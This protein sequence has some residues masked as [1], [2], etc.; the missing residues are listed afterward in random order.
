MKEIKKQIQKIF[1]EVAE[2][3]I[4]NGHVNMYKS[5]NSKKY[6]ILVKTERSGFQQIDFIRTIIKKENKPFYIEYELIMGNHKVVNTKKY[7]NEYKRL[8]TPNAMQTVFLFDK[9]ILACT[10]KILSQQKEI[11]EIINKRNTKSH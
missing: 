2:D 11:K 3:A 7:L 9:L 8:N 4:Q 10:K 5:E 6:N 1:F